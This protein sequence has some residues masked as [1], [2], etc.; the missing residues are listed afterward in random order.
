MTS[1]GRPCSSSAWRARVTHSTMFSSSL[2]QGMTTETLIGRLGA[3]GSVGVRRSIV[4]M[5]ERTVRGVQQK[6]RAGE[7]KVTRNPAEI[8]GSG[9]ICH[10][11][12]ARYAHL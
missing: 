12:A 9:P 10:I 1:P 4:L 8:D 2:R 3:V 6:K 11:A 7:T 5:A